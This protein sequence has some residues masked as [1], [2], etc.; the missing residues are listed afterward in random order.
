MA[1]DKEP[2]GE[3]LQD[4]LT[5]WSH[6][7]TIAQLKQDLDDSQ[8]TH[9]A[10]VSQISTWLDHMHVKGTAA[11]PKVEGKSSVQPKLIRT[12]AEWRYP[13]LSEPFLS[14]PNIFNV[15]P[16]TWEDRDAA[17]Q[18]MLL[19]NHQFNNKVG[20]QHFIDTLVRA[21][22][23][24]GVGLVKVGWTRIVE[25]VEEEKPVYELTPDPQYM[26]IMQQLDQ[27]QQE[28]P[29]DYMEVDEGY[30]TAHE[31]Y[32]QD[33]V[34]YRPEIVDYQ[35][36]EVEKV[37]KNQPSLEVCSYKNVIID[38]TCGGKIENASFVVHKFESSLSALKK[39]GRYK[40]LDKIDVTGATP[41][42]EPDFSSTTKNGSFQFTDKPRS[43]IVV[44]EYWGFRD[45]DGSGVV[46]P[47]VAAWVGAVLIRM[48]LNP[49]PDGQIP[50]V[51]MAY[52]P[53]FDSVY[54]ESDGSLLIDN[55]KV[56]GA[57]SRGMIDVMAK[58]ANGQTG[59]QKGAL[60]AVNRK[61]FEA[62]KDYEYNPG[63]D[64]RATIHQHT[65]PELPQSA[66]YMLQLQNQ[67]AEGM[68][69]VQAF[70]G[71]ISGDSLG[72]TATG[73]RGALDAASK[74]ELGI[75]RRIAEGIV[76]IGRKFISMNSVFLDDQEVVRITND[77][78]VAVKKDD[79]DGSFDLK[80]TISTAEED[81][82]KAEELAFVLQ[83]LGPNASWEI[84]AMI[85]ADIARLRKM[86]DLAHK[87]EKYQPQPDPMAQQKAQLEL[88]LLQ[89]QIETERARA[90]S[91]GATA[92]LSGQK[93]DTEAAKAQHLRSAAD[94][95]DLNFVEQE[96]GVKQER[97]LQSLHA[98]AA[99]QGKMKMLESVIRQNEPAQMNKPGAK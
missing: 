27:M 47:I 18:N 67:Q 35:M 26:Q 56:V 6:E 10:Q 49:F 80:L 78:F 75:L 23:D 98:Q 68:T 72:K 22:V 28:S 58:S 30:R 64:P 81:N 79:L 46:Q 66:Q 91:F 5:E 71:G 60:D 38:P 52:L 41:L 40:N 70:S 21:T 84:T 4:K 99:T 69:G 39:D 63:N 89:M 94:M 34:A 86:P 48:E 24:T 1:Q 90:A 92:N 25:E 19:L 74:R 11:I 50:F 53:T 20:K 65:F 95:N 61:R 57:V 8:T 9:Q 87:I 12:Q 36:V 59:V 85:L 82:A 43:K 88:Q 62:G 54:G 93:I 32:Q 3:K 29:S 96:S 83:T 45:I 17:K 33:G 7:P 55:Q 44:H 13:A 42:S 51:T 31:S 76:V 15:S 14:A 97:D 77:E 73:A 2:V 16:V 37:I